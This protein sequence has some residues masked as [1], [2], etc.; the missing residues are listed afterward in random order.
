MSVFSCIYG[1]RTKV[2]KEFVW[3]IEERIAAD[4]SEHMIHLNGDWFMDRGRK[5]RVGEWMFILLTQV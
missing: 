5:T 2:L 3:K 4:M 1:I